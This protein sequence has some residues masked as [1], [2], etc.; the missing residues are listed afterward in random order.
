MKIVILV[1]NIPAKIRKEVSN[2]SNYR[3][4]V[5]KKTILRDKTYTNPA[6]KQ[7]PTCSVGESCQ[8]LNGKKKIWLY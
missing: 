3:R 2:A 6:D 7:I 5:I 1:V 8:L 4:N